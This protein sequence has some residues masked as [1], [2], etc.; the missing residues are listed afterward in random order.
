MLLYDFSGFGR[1]L[2][3]PSD[4]YN[5]NYS[6][7]GKVNMLNRILDTL[8]LDRLVQYSLRIQNLNNFQLLDCFF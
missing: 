7:E 4:V 6:P 3:D 8:E 2:I 1:S 5:I